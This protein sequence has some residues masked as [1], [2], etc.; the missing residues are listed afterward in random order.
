MLRTI[1]LAREL[2]NKQ[3]SAINIS[4]A[5]ALSSRHTSQFRNS[6]DLYK[7]I[8]ANIYMMG[9]TKGRTSAIKNYND[10]STQEEIISET[11]KEIIIKE[12]D[13]I[14]ERALLFSNGTL[15]V[16]LCE[17]PDIKNTIK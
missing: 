17:A 14:K 12:I 6:E 4:I 3:N 13:A 15:D 16:L 8:R 7:F 1:Q 10:A 5:S 11:P 2:S 9:K